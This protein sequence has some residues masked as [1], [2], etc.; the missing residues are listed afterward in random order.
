MLNIPLARKIYDHVIAHPEEFEMSS[1]AER[2]ACGT[3]LCIAGHAVQM[4]GHEI[5]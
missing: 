2:T 3:T 1:Y 4:T 5:A